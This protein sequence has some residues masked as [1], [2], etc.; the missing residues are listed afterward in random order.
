MHEI[1]QKFRDSKYK[2]VRSVEW[3]FSISN[4]PVIDAYE[5]VLS[6]YHNTFSLTLSALF[7]H[8]CSVTGAGR[9]QGGA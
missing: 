6:S 2:Q 7:Y 8:T 5:D 9:Q 4:G 1:N 3:A